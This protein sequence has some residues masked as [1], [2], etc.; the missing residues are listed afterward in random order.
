MGYLFVLPVMASSIVGGVLYNMNPTYPWYAVGIA[1]AVQL[2]CVL[3]F[4]R[5]PEKAQN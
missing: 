1:T 2:V 3:L 4:I 5:D